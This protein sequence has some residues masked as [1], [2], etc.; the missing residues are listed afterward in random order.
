MP[1]PSVREKL[2]DAGFQLIWKNGYTGTG[3]RDVV[4]L[5]GARPGSFTNHFRSKEDFASEIV[6]RYGSYVRTVIDDALSDDGLSGPDRLRRYLDAITTRLAAASWERGCMLGN[7]CLET[8]HHSERLRVALAE[9]FERW[10]APLAACIAD[11]QAKGE[12][13]RRFDADELADVLLTGWQGAILRM[14]VTRSPAPLESFKKIVF[15]SM[16]GKDERS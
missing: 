15:T 1:R 4:A 5:A 3:V 13:A 11:A 8:S 6:D 2:L 14:K 16:F 9:I 10:R 7:L 12:I